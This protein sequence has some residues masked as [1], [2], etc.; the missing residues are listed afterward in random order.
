MDAAGLDTVER[1]TLPL[2]GIESQASNPQR[3]TILAELS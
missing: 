1:K 2:L 3:V